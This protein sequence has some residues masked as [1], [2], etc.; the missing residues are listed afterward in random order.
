MVLG[1]NLAD[2]TNNNRDLSFILADDHVILAFPADDLLTR[3]NMVKRGDIIDIY[4]SIDLEVEIVD[5]E[6]AE[7]DAEPETDTFT[8][9]AMQRVGVTALVLDIIDD[10]SFANT[11]QNLL[12]DENGQVTDMNYFINAI[13]LA[14][15]PQDALVLKHLKDTGAIFDIV[16]RSPT[17]EVQFDLTP[18]TE[19]YIIE[20]YGLEI[21]P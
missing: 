15:N 6:T 14:L 1:H 19:Q 16:L 21:L 5:G 20:Y 3:Q 2:P 4:A 11:D 8:M 7:E 17:S 18:V 10:G 12:M 9:D 13:L